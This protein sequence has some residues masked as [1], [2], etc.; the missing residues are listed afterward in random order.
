MKFSQLAAIV[1]L[2]EFF[3]AWLHPNT[4]AVLERTIVRFSE[5][6]SPGQLTAM[7]RLEAFIVVDEIILLTSAV[8][9]KLEHRQKPTVEILITLRINQETHSGK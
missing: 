8:G 3:G 7:T 9:L 6:P 4:S 5:A 2:R 1:V